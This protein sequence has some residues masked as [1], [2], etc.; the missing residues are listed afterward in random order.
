[1]KAI[2]GGTGV[3]TLEDLVASKTS[4]K[5]KYGE[6]EL[7]L[8]EGKD[9]SLVF[10]P[11]HGANHGVPPHLINYRANIAALKTLG[12]KQAIGIYAVGSISEALAPKEVGLVEDFIDFCGG[13]REHSFYTGQE[14]GV[15]HVGMDQVFDLGLQEKLLG[16][17][18]SLKRAGIY[19]C[20]NG[21]RL[22]TRSEIQLFKA[23][24][25]DIVGMTLASEA[26]LLKEAEIPYAALAYSI[27]W[28]AGIA[29]GEVCFVDAEVIASLRNRMTKLCRKALEV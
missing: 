10:L 12:V 8:G 11:R 28:A 27:N 2:I 6:V 3:D 17:D 19:V 9:S 20:T 5:T 7:F 22:E 21:P 26:A 13:G 16:L 29:H 25:C 4:I 24:G 18:S 15:K 23:W 1:M 14:Q